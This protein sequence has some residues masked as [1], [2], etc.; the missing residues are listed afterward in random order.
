M[1][2]LLRNSITTLFK[3]LGIKICNRRMKV[4]LR[5]FSN[6]IL[7]KTVNTFKKTNHMKKKMKWNS[8]GRNITWLS[9]IS[10]VMTMN[11]WMSKVKT[12][13]SHKIKINKKMPNIYIE[14]MIA[15]KRIFLYQANQFLQMKNKNS[16]RT[17]VVQSKMNILNIIMNMMMLMN[18]SVKATSDPVTKQINHL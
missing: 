2:L 9:R 12:K 10:M 16:L 5:T 13:C 15:R 7:S 11:K 18:T 6:K 3:Y 14:D 4:K 17:L 8:K 1:L